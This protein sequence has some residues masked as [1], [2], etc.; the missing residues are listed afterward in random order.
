[1][2]KSDSAL[3]AFVGKVILPSPRQP[4]AIL[5]NL[6]VAAPNGWT[7]MWLSARRVASFPV[8][9]G[10]FLGGVSMVGVRLR[11]PYPDTWWHI[12]VGQRILDT[13]KWPTSDPYSFTAFGAHWIAYE[14]LGE[15]AMALVAHAG[16]LLGLATLQI[17]LA[18]IATVLLYYYAYARSGDWKAACTATGLLLPIATVSFALRPQLFGY[19]YLLVTLICLERFRRGYS[20]SL[21]ILP[22]LF[23]IWVNTHGT[24]VFGLAAIVVYFAC[25][26]ASF[27]LGGLIAERWSRRQ[28]VQLLVTF[29]LC[30]LATLVTPY[31]AQLAAYPVLMA[32]TQPL[33]IAHVQEWQSV[34]FE[35]GLGKYFLGLLLMIF[36]AHIFYPVKYRLQEMAMLLFAVYAACVHIRFML[37]F[38]MI[39]GPIVA[40]FLVRWM[41]PYDPNKNQ[42]GLNLAIIVVMII[43]LAALMPG[44]TALANLVAKDYP[45]GAI[46]YLQQHPQPTGMFNEYS[47]GGY[48]IWQLGPQ[49][50]VFI[51]GRAD[52]YEYSG[53]FQ[54]YVKIVNLDRDTLSLLRKYNIQSCLIQ[55]KSALATLLAA[56]PDWKQTYA[57]DLSVIIARS[58]ASAH[59]G[60]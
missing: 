29:L 51:D 21:W 37:I 25:G 24:F 7:T 16:G 27:Q 35:V 38:V 32:T 58:P 50:K 13:H 18:A 40:G 45:V 48:L 3:G 36:L 33:N 31:G 52:M 5:T 43:S 44:K 23:L 1:M 14:W 53:A 46:Q 8:L 4:E 19:I 47:Y 57:D 10:L 56:S 6:P 20:R 60:N 39:V 55:R 30:G 22:P 26:L 59:A 9:M 2:S 12:A 28:K 34:S 15:I 11:S 49:Q 54:D 41:P 42:F 17:C